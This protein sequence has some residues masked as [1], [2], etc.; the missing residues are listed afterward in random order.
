MNTM[1]D[2][3]HKIIDEAIRAVLPEKAVER[4]LSS[5]HVKNGAVIVAIGKAAWNMAKAAKDL[6]GA[7]ISDGIVLTK[8]HHSKG[9]IEGLK[10]FEAGHPLPD[11]N[12]VIG[13]S[14]ILELVSQLTSDDEVVFLVSGGG[15]ALFEKPLHGITLNEIVSVTDQLLSCAASIVEINTVRKHLSAV[16]G[17]RFASHC[18]GAKIHAVVLSDV[19]G[20]PLNAIASGPAYPDQSTSEEALA[21]IKKYDLQITENIRKALQ[22]ETPKA[23]E[24]CDTVITGS[25]SELCEA[26]AATASAL[27]YHPHILSSFVENEAKEIGHFFGSIAK[28]LKKVNKSQY[29]F[30]TPCA[31]ILGG[32]TVVHLKGKGKGGRNQELVLAAAI[33]IENIDDVIIFSLGS[34]GT[35]GPTD[36]AG[37]IVDGQSISRMKSACKNPALMLDNNDAYHAL[38]ASND[39]V[40]TGPTGTNV[41]DLIVLL[42]R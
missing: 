24:N 36:A 6:L 23:V 39:L 4:A 31:I 22:E 34:D 42:C 19:I 2:D 33:E 40:I 30:Q 27:N 26:A 32:E 28:E 12:S 11:Q 41:N 8:Y 17:G 15:S 35:D 1:R 9:D 37:G 29:T 10:I 18:N 3:A 5:M 14:K 25:V 7:K 16:K 21:I 38:E 20:D 13:T